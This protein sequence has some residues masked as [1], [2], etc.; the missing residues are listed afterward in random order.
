MM[1]EYFSRVQGVKTIVL[2]NA[3]FGSA[4]GFNLKTMG[5]FMLTQRIC[6][7][8]DMVRAAVLAIEN[9]VL[10]HEVFLLVND[11][12]FTKQDLPALRTNPEQVV[13]K[14]Y[15]GGV[16]LLKEYG[17][18]IQEI[19]RRKYLWKLDD[20]SKAKRLLGWKPTFT[21][22]DFYEKLKAGRYPKDYVF[23]D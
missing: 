5:S 11:T 7:R 20:N 6:T 2:R 1:G 15:P 22:R 17:I 10:E 23:H 13:E 3:G 19:H 8:K 4:R 18:D 21:F 12:E 16:A 14:H 9:N